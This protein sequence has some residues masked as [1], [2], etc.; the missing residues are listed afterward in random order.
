MNLPAEEV[1]EAIFAIIRGDRQALEERPKDAESVWGR[2][3]R[4]KFGVN[5]PVDRFWAYVAFRNKSTGV[6][7]CTRNYAISNIF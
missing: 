2:I 5:K 1:A 3:V 4:A 7:V 6:E